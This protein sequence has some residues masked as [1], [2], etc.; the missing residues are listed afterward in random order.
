MKKNIKALV[1]VLRNQQVDLED[2]INIRY[3]ILAKF[4][5]FRMMKMS[6]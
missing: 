1:S 3:G 5:T 6:Q 4:L 2:F